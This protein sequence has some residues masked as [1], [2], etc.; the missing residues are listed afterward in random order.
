LGEY[1]HTGWESRKKYSNNI[2][3]YQQGTNQVG[4]GYYK[5]KTTRERNKQGQ[6]NLHQDGREGSW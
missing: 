1:R 2:G 4:S 5:S 3:E 6:N